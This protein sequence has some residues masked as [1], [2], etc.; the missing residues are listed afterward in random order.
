MKELTQIKPVSWIKFTLYGLLLLGI[1]YSSFTWLITHDWEREAYSY[2]WLI[3]PVVFFLIWIKRD[4][5]V[6]TP[7]EPSWTGLVPVGVGIVFFWLGEL[8]GEFFTLYISF[9]LVLVGICLLHLGWQ[10]LKTIG[11]ALFFILTMFPVPNF[12]NTRLMLQLRLISSKLGVGIIQFWGLP[13]YREGNII[14]LGFTQLQVVD[15]CS[16]CTL[17]FPW[18]YCACCWSIFSRIISGS[19]RCC[20]FHPYPWLLLPT[21]CALL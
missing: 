6:S 3:P 5:L 15:A 4:D 11:F 7:S 18:W 20:C 17:S 21:A 19:G 14:D 16:G 10:K 1:Y 8:S 12:I 9:W 13:A 2:C